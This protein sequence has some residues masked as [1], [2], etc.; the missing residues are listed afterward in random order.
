MECSH[1]QLSA[2]LTDGLRR[3]DTHR[4]TQLHQTTRREVASVAL[5]ANAALGLARENRTNLDLVDAGLFDL[6]RHFFRDFL[7]R[8]DDRRIADDIH[9]V[10]QRHA[11]DDSLAERNHDLVAFD[12]RFNEN[13]FDG[14]AIFQINDDVLSHVHKTTCQVTRIRGLKSGIGQTLTGAVR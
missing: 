4:F 12:D 2:R 3:D 7:A 1:G 13:T 14:T 10:I 5:G 8:F 11:T 9:D 6:L